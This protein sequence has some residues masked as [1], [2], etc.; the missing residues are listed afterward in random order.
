MHKGIQE[1]IEKRSSSVSQKLKRPGSHLDTPDTDSAEIHNCDYTKTKVT[2]ECTCTES[3]TKEC[4][5]TEP[6]ILQCGCTEPGAQECK[7]TDQGRECDNDT[8]IPAKRLRHE[9]IPNTSTSSREN[10]SSNA[11]AS[12]HSNSNTSVTLSAGS[13]LSTGGQWAAGFQAR[14]PGSE[15]S[16]NCVSVARD[17]KDHI[18]MTVFHALLDRPGEVVHVEGNRGKTWRKGGVCVSEQ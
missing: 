11:A 10:S 9:F 15:K 8:P 7:C 6:G 16:R 14:C 12:S 4:Q 2:Q 13:E 5:C 18:T 3:G 1:Y 17:I